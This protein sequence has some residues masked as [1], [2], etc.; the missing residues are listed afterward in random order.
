[1][2]TASALPLV[3]RALSSASLSAATLTPVMIG[4][5][6]PRGLAFGPEGALYVVEAG[7][8][9]TDSCAM[10]R[11]LLRCQG[12]SGAL[13]RLWKG[14]QERVAFGF[15]SY[16]DAGANETTGAHDVAFLGRGH[17]TV[18]IGFGGAPVLREDFG[19]AGAGFGTLIQVA[20][21]G[22]WQYV[23]D[24][25]AYEALAN[26]AGGPVDTNPYGLLAEPGA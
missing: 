8:G 26:P 21:S 22:Q 7:R 9:G 16:S 3:M 25:S 19:P 13:S 12:P 18:S 15:P 23:A 11:G 20:A 17:A 6:N 5:D 10:L 1:M 4:L 24:V 14:T 2:K